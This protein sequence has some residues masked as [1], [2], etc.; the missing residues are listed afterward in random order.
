MVASPLSGNHVKQEPC[1]LSQCHP[2]PTVFYFSFLI[3]SSTSFDP[4]A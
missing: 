1:R 4:L 3:S 2:R